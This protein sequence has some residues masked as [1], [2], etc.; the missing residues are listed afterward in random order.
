MDEINTNQTRRIL[1]PLLIKQLGSHFRVDTLK[2]I[3][4]ILIK[5]CIIKNSFILKEE[6]QVLFWEVYRKA[7]EKAR[8]VLKNSEHYE[9]IVESFEND[10]K[11]ICQRILE[12]K[13]DVGY[14]AFLTPG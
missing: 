14:E 13:V 5:L 6:H 11:R 9:Y 12:S 8:Q 4:N 1:I 7:I 2:N 3:A 10:E